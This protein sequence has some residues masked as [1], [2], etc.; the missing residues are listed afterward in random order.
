MTFGNHSGMEI[1]VEAAQAYLQRQMEE[2][3][4]ETIEEQTENSDSVWI[5]G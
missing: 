2:A 1:D 5:S 4:I 3:K